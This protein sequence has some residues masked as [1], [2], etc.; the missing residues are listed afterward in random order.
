MAGATDCRS[1]SARTRFRKRAAL[2]LGLSNLRLV[3]CGLVVLAV[4]PGCAI[5]DHLTISGTGRL[6]D[7]PAGRSAVLQ[8][9]ARA[10]GVPK[11]V[12][13]S[14]GVADALNADAQFA[15]LAAHAAADDGGMTVMLPFEADEVLEKAGLEATLHPKPKQLKQFVRTLGCSSYMTADIKRWRHRHLFFFSSATIEYRLSCHRADDGQVLWEVH[16]R[17][18]ARGISNRE[19]ARLALYETF[20]W[21]KEQ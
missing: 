4:S 9:T 19:L 11:S 5:R 7:T 12:G 18:Q 2:R 1:V 21:L 15:E 16:I 6:A 8:V 14:W 3:V 17:K 13:I 20:Q 10:D